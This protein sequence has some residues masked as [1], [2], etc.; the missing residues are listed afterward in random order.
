MSRSKF[1][2]RFRF[3]ASA[4]CILCSVGFILVQ[5]QADRIRPSRERL[6]EKLIYIPGPQF[7]KTAALGF[8]AVIADILW[9]RAVVY[10]GEH[11][12]TDKDYS[13]LYRILDVAT[14]LDPKNI[15]AYRF[16]GTLLALEDSGVDESTAL[17]KKGIQNNPE[18]DWRLYFLLG[19]NHFYLL[20][21]YGAAA[22]YLEK[23]SRMPRHPTYLPRLVARMYAK[24][25]KVDVAIEF[26]REAYQQYDDENVKS[27]IAE[28][29]TAL[30]AKKEARSLEHAAQKYKE[31][32]GEYPR[33]LKALVGAGIIRE[34]RVYPGGDYVI[35]P[36]TGKVDWIQKSGPQWP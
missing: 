5:R 17:L 33:E 3:L 27:A 18:E 30:I 14:T 16:G 8:D 32:F 11:Y 13:W 25:D 21:D 4:L 23:A 12:L 20:E 1:Q 26:L 7:I 36:D 34:L 22:E 19:F 10:F 2:K 24:A 31:V 28:R 29:M 9:A 6:E 35:D 15:L